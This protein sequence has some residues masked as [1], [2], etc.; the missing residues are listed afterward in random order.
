VKANLFKSSSQPF[1]QKTF[2]CPW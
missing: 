1:L 2:H